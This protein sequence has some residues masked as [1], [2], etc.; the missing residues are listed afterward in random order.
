MPGGVP[1]WPGKAPNPGGRPNGDA[2]LELAPCLQARAG[3]SPP[4]GLYAIFTSRKQCYQILKQIKVCEVTRKERMSKDVLLS[5]AQDPQN[6]K[7][8]S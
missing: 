1:F 6:S 2:V 8:T 4:Y 7:L 5:S 3:N